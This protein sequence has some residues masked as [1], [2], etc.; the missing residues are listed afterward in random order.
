VGA[1]TLLL[2]HGWL[3]T[4]ALN[5]Q[6]V[7][8]PL[9]EHFRVVAP[10]LRGHGRGLKSW[11]RFRLEDCADDVAAVLDRLDTGPVIAAGYS[12]GGPVAQLLW[13]RHRSR[14]AGLVLCATSDRMTPT[15]A[16]RFAQTTVMGAVMGTTRLGQLPARLPRWVASR[17]LPKGVKG[18]ALN[19]GDWGMR[20]VK[21]HDMRML[22]EAG[23]AIGRHDAKPW[24]ESVDVPTSVLVTLEDRAV[25][26]H[27]Q[28]DMATRIRG[29]KVFDVQ[30]GHVLC[31]RAEFAEPLVDACLDVK[32]RAFAR[33]ADARTRRRKRES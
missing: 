15:N 29:A 11:R 2:L 19:F 6:H 20:E 21:N 26:A 8:E 31:N 24:I 27:L 3:A 14:V 12:M 25:P 32:R 4:G 7:F 22:M 5:W 16:Q 10:D 33:G 1:P 18:P 13:R 17:M 30:E 9:S 23:Y 28:Q